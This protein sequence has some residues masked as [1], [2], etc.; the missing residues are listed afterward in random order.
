MSLFSFHLS[1]HL[2]R[3]SVSSVA[4]QLTA[5][6]ESNILKKDWQ[7]KLLIF[8]KVCLKMKSAQQC[9]HPTGG[10]R[11]VFRQFHG[12]NMVPSKWRYLVPPTSG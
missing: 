7:Q 10:S 9:V 6:A 5:E 2:A 1:F 8:E 11:R 3:C 12:F 4:N